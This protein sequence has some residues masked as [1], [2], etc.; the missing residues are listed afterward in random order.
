MWT[1][2][3]VSCTKCQVNFKKY[4]LTTNKT[5]I[6]WIH[7]NCTIYIIAARFNNFQ[8][9]VFL[10]TLH[11]CSASKNA[12]LSILHFR[13]HANYFTLPW[14]IKKLA[15][16]QCSSSSITEGSMYRVKHNYVSIQLFTMGMDLPEIARLM[17]VSIY[18]F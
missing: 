18:Y 9:K 16:D 15:D 14:K 13:F 11:V 2:P 12:V 1:Q 10:G 3:R 7:N 8:R 17:E 4:R 6:C 5:T